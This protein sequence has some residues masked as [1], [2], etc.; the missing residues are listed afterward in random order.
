MIQRL[1][2]S[3]ARIGARRALVAALVVSVSVNL[4]L[5]GAIAGAAM[6]RDAPPEAPDA[7]AATLAHALRGGP[8]EMRALTRETLEARRPAYR[9]LRSALGEAQREAARAA[10]ADP[11]DTG[12]L[13]DALSDL[14]RAQDALAV[15]GHETVLALLAAAPP[16]SRAALAQRLERM[17]TRR[18][19][20]PHRDGDARESER[21][22]PPR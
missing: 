2:S 3:L 7:Q 21:A 15:F 22:G 14:R 19:G 4:L 6:R 16:E 12:A 1:R 18:G 9:A 13:R 8:P 20:A 5:G 17:W 11:F 10:R